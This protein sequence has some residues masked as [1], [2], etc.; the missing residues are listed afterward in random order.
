MSTNLITYRLHRIH[1]MTAIGALLVGLTAGAINIPAA[2]ATDAADV[3]QEFSETL[4]AIKAYSADKRDEAAAA[5]QDMVDALDERMNALERKIENASDA[6]SEATR[7]KWAETK[8]GL[9]K[10]RDK[11]AMQLDHMRDSSSEAWSDAKDEF[12]DAVEELGESIE[13]AGEDLQS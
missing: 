8:A 10:L 12:T 4:D 13:D 1:A 2:N 6:T 5:G 7:A 3:K 9:M 11:A